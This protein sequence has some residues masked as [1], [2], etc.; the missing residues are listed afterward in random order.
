MLSRVLVTSL[1]LLSVATLAKG[2]SADEQTVNDEQIGFPEDGLFSGSTFDSVQTNNGNLHIEIPLW[3]VKGRGIPVTVKMI[4]DSKAWFIRSHCNISSGLC[5]GTVA[6]LTNNHR[7]LRVVSDFD[8]AYKGGAISKGGCANARYGGFTWYEPDGSSHHL[9]PDPVCNSV[10]SPLYADD[11]SGWMVQTTTIGG[12][13][14]ATRKDGLTVVLPS[15]GVVLTDSNGN[16][17]TRSSSGVN[18]DT[19]G[20][21]F[22]TDGSYVD[23]SGV[24][25]SLQI[26]NTTVPFATHLCQF[27]WN[28]DDT[29]NESSG[30]LTAPQ[31]V[32]LPNGME[33]TFQYEQNQYGEPNSVTLPTGGQISWTWGPPV[34]TGG[35][36]VASRTETAN[37]VSSTWTY[38]YTYS[39]TNPSTVDNHVVTATITDPAGN[40]AK[41][42]FT[43]DGSGIPL[44]TK[45]CYESMTQSF[46]GSSQ[47]GTLLKTLS[48]TYTSIGTTK[49]PTTET[50]TWNQQNL[51]SKVERD[52]DSFVASTGVTVTWKNPK[53]TRE[54]DFDAG[55]PGSLVRKTL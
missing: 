48:K 49:L 14:K 50:T 55:S 37:G 36:W 43:C 7:T 31:L 8:Y 20:R 13:Q 4:F 53:E 11:G 25:R 5:T 22:A 1:L 44:V 42:T 23:S 46:S 35:R 45:A 33:Y 54:F 32:T 41:T 16:Q 24:L 26:T 12:F 51:V 15:G 17:I 28:G 3:T 10:P 27:D 47:S 52:W 38:T 29:C 2:Q 19:A 21:T 40:D 30:S 18:T 6:A 39:K 9:V 34:S